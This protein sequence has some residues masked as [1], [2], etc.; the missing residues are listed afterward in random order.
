MAFALM[1]LI[2][3]GHI[4]YDGIEKGVVYGILIWA[5]V[6]CVKSANLIAYTRI[7]IIYNVIWLF[8]GLIT[9]VIY[10]GVIYLLL[11]PHAHLWPHPDVLKMAIPRAVQRKSSKR[12]STKKKTRRK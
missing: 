4:P 8:Q 6:E 12:K 3:R 7:P 9:Y 2:V 10:G 11:E 1:Y 5:M